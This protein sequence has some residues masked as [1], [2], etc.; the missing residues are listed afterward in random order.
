MTEY[1]IIDSYPLSQ[2]V[3]AIATLGGAGND[4]SAYIYDVPGID[5][6]LERCIVAKHGSKLS[7]EVASA[8]FP[9]ISEKYKWRK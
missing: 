1:N 7:K 8:L 4:W 6:D 2:R 9:R 3:L 5:H